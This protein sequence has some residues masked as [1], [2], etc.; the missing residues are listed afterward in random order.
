[1]RLPHRRKR[2]HRLATVPEYILNETEQLRLSLYLDYA[3]AAN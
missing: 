1:M 2:D 3:K